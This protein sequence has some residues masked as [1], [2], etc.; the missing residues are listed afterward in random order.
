M[1]G[2]V[3][4]KE[5]KLVPVAYGMNKLQMSAVVEDDKFESDDLIDKV[6]SWE[7]VQSVD[8]AGMQKL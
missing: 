6:Q 2:L 5:H 7:E 1:D 4:G 3:W 8:I